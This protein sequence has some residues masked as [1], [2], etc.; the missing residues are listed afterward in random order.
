M[1]NASR[2]LWRVVEPYHQVAYRS[3]E[4]TAAYTKLGLTIPPHQYFANRVAVMGPVGTTTAAAVLFGFNPAY[5]A[6]AIPEVWTIADPRLVCEARRDAAVDCLRRIIPGIEE[7]ALAIELAAVAREIVVRLDFAGSPIGAACFDQPY[8]EAPDARLWHSCTVL[9]EHRGDA[10]WRATAAH[11]IDPVECHILH[12]ADGA[13]PEDLLQRVTGWDDDAWS[14]ARRRL[15]QRGLVTN[16]VERPV[17]TTEGR[18]TKRAIEAA[19]DSHAD[20]AIESVG[21]T[22]VL[23]FRELMRPWITAIMDADVIG[24][25]KIREELWRDE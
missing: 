12:A 7:S 9:R 17:L 16:S 25:W 15:R 4:A 5:V 10:H 23:E 22:R 18:L 20:R 11:G 13:M 6:S 19:T 14:D 21:I 3:P 8:P 1:P 2:E 24:A